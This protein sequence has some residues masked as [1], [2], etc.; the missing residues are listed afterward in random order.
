MGPS[1]H[2]EETKTVKYGKKKTPLKPTRTFSIYDYES[3]RLARTGECL[4]NPDDKDLKNSFKG[5]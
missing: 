2:L 3:D 5:Q 4:K 1:A